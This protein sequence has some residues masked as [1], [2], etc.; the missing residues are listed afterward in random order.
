MLRKMLLAL[1]LLAAEEFDAIG[2]DFRRVN[3]VSFLVYVAASLDSSHYTDFAALGQISVTILR[4]LA[5]DYDRDK[6][7]NVF[8]LLCLRISAALIDGN[9]K[10][11]DR[12][13]VGSC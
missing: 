11:A 3:F 6:T 10:S 1:S 12:S 9:R 8:P 7:W 5:E 2:D 13:L 4:L